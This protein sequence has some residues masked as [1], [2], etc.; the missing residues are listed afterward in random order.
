M[1]NILIFP[2]EILYY[3]LDN[4][5]KFEELNNKL[6]IMKKIILFLI[7]CQFTFFANAQ[8]VYT[9][10]YSSQADVKV[11][12]VD[13]ESQADLCVYKVDYS[14]QAGKND[15]NWYFVDYS[16]QA[17]KKIFFTDYSS[18]ADVKIYF[19]EY[20]SQAKWKKKEQMHLFY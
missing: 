17:D 5:Y 16:S 14:S 1:S 19:V 7:V 4:F 9:V 8:K 12:V 20:R 10:E 3:L 11:F 6:I 15:G 13:Y 2:V 18:Q